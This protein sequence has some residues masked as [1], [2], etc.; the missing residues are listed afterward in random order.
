MKQ[1][2]SLTHKLHYKPLALDKTY[3]ASALESLDVKADA[4]LLDLLDEVPATYNP[5]GD[6]TVINVS[7]ILIPRASKFEK[8]LGYSGYKDIRDALKKAKADTSSTVVLHFDSPGGTVDGVKETAKLIKELSYTKDVVA[9]TEGL[10][11]SAAYWLAAQCGGIFSSE[12]AEIGSIGVYTA[13]LTYGRALEN[14]GIT[15]EVIQAGKFKT[16]GTALKDLTEE[17]RAMLQASVDSTYQTFLN[18]VAHR[19]LDESITQGLTYDGVEAYANNLVDG[20]VSSVEEL[21][22][23]LTMS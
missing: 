23:V 1:I 16:L 4:M 17:E 5:L 10:L 7:G 6:V 11:C 12:S 19:N 13:F 18:A 22:S 2:H 21:L 9:Y 20:H 8:L 14:E 15:A 3:F